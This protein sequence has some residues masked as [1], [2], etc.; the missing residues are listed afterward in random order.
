MQILDPPEL[1]T[2]D[3]KLMVGDELN[4]CKVNLVKRGLISKQTWIDKHGPA[5]AKAVL[6]QPDNARGSGQEGM[7]DH[8]VNMGFR[9]DYLRALYV[10]LYAKKSTNTF[11]EDAEIAL[12][13]VRLLVED[14]EP[15]IAD[16]IPGYELGARAKI[17]EACN[18]K[19]VTLS[20]NKQRTSHFSQSAIAT[21]YWSPS[22]TDKDHIMT[23]LGGYSHSATQ[24]GKDDEV[25]FYFVFPSIGKAIPMRS[26]DI[27]LFD[28]RVAHCATNYRHEDSYIFSLFTS[29]KT[30]HTKMAAVEA[31]SKKKSRR[32]H[33]LIKLN[34]NL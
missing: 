8:S 13:G 22:H 19:A 26:T 32:Q 34:Q 14:V 12:D 9:L 24:S 4:A 6:V 7:Y 31:S 23:M 29:S 3:M 20:R 25:L 33:C 10:A 30:I 18:G 16:I 28:S 5:L 11:V 17:M 2:R 1:E 27:L 21:K 15:I